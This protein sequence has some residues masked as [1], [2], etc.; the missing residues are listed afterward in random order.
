[1]VSNNCCPNVQYPC[2]HFWGGKCFNSVKLHFYICVLWAFI[3]IHVIFTEQRGE[4]SEVLTKRATEPIKSIA[5]MCA[6]VFFYKCSNIH[7]NKL[8]K[9]VNCHW[10][11]LKNKWKSFIYMIIYVLLLSWNSHCIHVFIQGSICD[12]VISW[13]QSF[14]A[15]MIFHRYADLSV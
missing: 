15:K 12:T 5:K 4:F 6:L 11:H 13:R 9:I 14:S 10:T 1:M 7:C 8:C 2:S 3:V